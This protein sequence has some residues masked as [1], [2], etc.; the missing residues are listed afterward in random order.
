MSGDLFRWVLED[1]FRVFNTVNKAEGGI[2]RDIA[3]LVRY[4]RGLD[5]DQQATMIELYLLSKSK[6]YNKKK[7][8]Y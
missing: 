4:H 8:A 6:G 3:D 7:I 5:V 1:S 2:N